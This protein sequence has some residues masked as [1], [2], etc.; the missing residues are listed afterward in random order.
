MPPAATVG[1][2]TIHGTPLSPGPGSSNVLNWWKT[3][4]EMVQLIFIH[5]HYLMVP[6]LMLEETY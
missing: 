5:V 6:N 3:C 4:L 1:D 2:Q